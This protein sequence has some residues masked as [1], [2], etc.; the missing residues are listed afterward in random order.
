M[1]GFS[2]RVIPFFLALSAWFTAPA[3]A[4]WEVTGSF[5]RIASGGCRI[6][7]TEPTAVD[8]VV[9]P[10]DSPEVFAPGS[11]G[12]AVIVRGANSTTVGRRSEPS[13]DSLRI[14][15]S[16]PSTLWLEIIPIVSEIASAA[17]GTTGRLY[18][19]GV[20]APRRGL[21]NELAELSK[22]TLLIQERNRCF[23]CHIGLP[24]AWTATLAEYRCLNTPRDTLASIAINIISLQQDDG[25]FSAAGHPEY[26]VVSPTLAA[27]ATLTYLQK[28]CTDT[29]VVSALRRAADFLIGHSGRKGLPEFD[30]TFPPL[31]IG[32]P[33]AARLFLDV[34]ETLRSSAAERGVP[35]GTHLADALQKATET[36][37]SGEAGY[38]KSLWRL[39]TISITGEAPSDA[40][41]SDGPSL[42]ANA[43]FAFSGERDPELLALYEGVLREQGQPVAEKSIPA[44]R[45]DDLKVRIWRLYQQLYREPASR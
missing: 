5:H 41:A 45:P 43:V 31:F 9:L 36:M 13:D 10:L 39:F 23:L 16:E 15:L 28:F 17:A 27:A 33:F 38:E 42:P 35:F 25:S 21:E 37:H 30:F 19:E 20:D 40:A 11:R 22:A 26:G 3:L 4:G 32:K 6:D 12:K 29:D 1:N 18:I 24:L 34:L 44:P 8:L 2:K 14:E 7:F